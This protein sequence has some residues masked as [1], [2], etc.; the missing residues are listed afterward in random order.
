[1]VCRVMASIDLGARRSPH[2]RLIG[3]NE[4]LANPKTPLV[5]RSAARP[6]SIPVCL[7]L[8]GETLSTE[9]VADGMPFG[10]ERT[11]PDGGR[12]FIFCPGIEADTGTEPLQSYDFERS[13]IYK[14]L[15]A[16]GAIADQR[17]YA[18]H[19]GF[20]NFFV[21]FVTATEARMRSMMRCLERI[22]DGRGSPIFLFKT[23]PAF[24][25]FERPPAPTGHM[26]TESWQ[27]VG[28]PPLDLAT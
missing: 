3:W 2:I 1:M 4:I 28:S 6:T 24:T 20:P 13:S 17:I 16:Y 7:T 27:R 15:L 19:F 25:A 5:L 23:F 11:R 10:I 26:L 9:I 8:S 12:A 22:T 14:K 18:S 21:P